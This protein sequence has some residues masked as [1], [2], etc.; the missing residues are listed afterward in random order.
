MSGASS[1]GPDSPDPKP[2]AALQR[3]EIVTQ[4][5]DEFGLVRSDAGVNPDKRSGEVTPTG[6]GGRHTDSVTIVA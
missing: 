3:V 5:I 6:G 2:A 1:E 4:E